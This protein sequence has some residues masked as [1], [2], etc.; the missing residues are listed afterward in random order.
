MPCARDVASNLGFAIVGVWGLWRLW[1]RRRE[2]ALRCG[3][4]GYALFLSSVT[5]TAFGSAYYHLAPDNARLVFDRLPIALACAGLLAAVR[6]ESHPRADP[7]RDVVLLAIVA[8]ASVAWW[9]FTDHPPG[10]GDLRAYVLVQGLPLVLIPL[11]QWTS[12]TAQADRVWFALALLVY[13]G[14]KAAELYDRELF[15][16]L[17]V[18][19]GHTLKHLLSALAA[20]VIVVR[21]D[22]RRA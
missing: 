10:A 5:L 1:P 11:W 4:P 17:G 3:F 16:A 18:M 14:A 9:R 12:P 7:R 22:R 15:A 8:V 19:S 2:T 20:A 21:L 13:V 6:A